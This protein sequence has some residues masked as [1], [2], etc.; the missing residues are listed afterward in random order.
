MCGVWTLASRARGGWSPAASNWRDDQP[1]ASRGG[2]NTIYYI[3]VSR[4]LWW[5]E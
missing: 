2:G 5:G 4:V 1:A 3:I